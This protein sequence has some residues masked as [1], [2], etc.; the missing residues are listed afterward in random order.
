MGYVLRTFGRN[1]QVRITGGYKKPAGATQAASKTRREPLVQIRRDLEAKIYHEAMRIIATSFIA[2]S[3]M[4]ESIPRVDLLD[5][6]VKL[7]ERMPVGHLSATSQNKYFNPIAGMDITFS[8]T[9]DLHE[10][11]RFEL[12]V[13]ALIAHEIG[14]NISPMS[15]F[16]FDGSSKTPLPFG[17][18]IIFPHIKDS[19]GDANIMNEILADFCGLFLLPQPAGR[20]RIKQ[21]FI[22]LVNISTAIRLNIPSAERNPDDLLRDARFIAMTRYLN[23]Y[24][25]TETSSKLLARYSSQKDAIDSAINRYSTFMSEIRINNVPQPKIQNPRLFVEAT[26]PFETRTGI[27]PELVLAKDTFP[28]AALRDIP[29]QERDGDYFQKGNHVL[30]KRQTDVQGDPASY[31]AEA[32]KAIVESV[33]S[34]RVEIAIVTDDSQIE[35]TNTVSD[36]TSPHLF[37]WD[38]NI[39]P[40]LPAG[41]ELKEQEYITKLGLPR[42]ITNTLVREGIIMDVSVLRKIPLELLLFLPSIDTAS[43]DLI[44]EALG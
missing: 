43:V 20:N 16:R 19:H 9:L 13:P 41:T 26:A 4:P 15:K 38:P 10:N 25:D 22:E 40:F 17:R 3:L 28:I 44:S 18:R 33:R 27:L 8:L 39:V 37:K 23:D 11:G 31:G 2:T 29:P 1:E 32:T 14:H 6:S 12:S 30:L 42:E 35:G 7:K 21:S 34:E 24:Q 36:I 5:V